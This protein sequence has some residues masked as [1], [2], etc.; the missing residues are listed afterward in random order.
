M[1]R[2]FFNKRAEDP[3]FQRLTFILLGVAS[4]GD[5]IRD[6]QRTPFN[7]GSSVTL[8]GFHPAEVK[9]LYSGLADKGADPEQ[10]LQSVLAWTGG[11]PFL[12][13][14]AC[15][16]LRNAE[17]RPQKDNVTTWVGKIIRREIITNWEAHDNPEHLKTIQDRILTSPNKQQ[18]LDL[19]KNILESGQTPDAQSP[20]HR[21]LQLTGLAAPRWGNLEPTN[22]IYRE[23]FDQ[24]WIKKHS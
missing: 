12:T 23:V 11:Q 24:T 2:A 17:T 9:P 8:T 1:I 21:E 5:L 20:I 14:K 10:I 22:A 7:I 15:H 19:Y 4:P 13:Q 18:L 16:I 3:R 6:K